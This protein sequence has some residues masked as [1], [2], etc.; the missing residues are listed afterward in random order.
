M[1][2]EKIKTPKPIDCSSCKFL[3]SLNFSEDLRFEICKSFWNLND[4]RRKKDFILM[5]V[6]CSLPKRRRPSKEPSE[7]SK[8]RTNSKSFFLL[9]KRV[10]QSFFLKTLA[11]SNGPLNKAFE[12]KNIYTNFFDG[13]DKRGK[14]TPSNKLSSA[15]VESVVNHCEKFVCQNQKSKR[16]TITN[17]D[18]RSLKQLYNLY[19]EDYEGNSPSYTSF[20][21]IF[22]ENNFAFPL[23]RVRSKPHPKLSDS[24]VDV[25]N[26]SESLTQ[27]NLEDEMTSNKEK[28]V[29][30]PDQPKVIVAQVPESS[31]YF[32]NPSSQVYE[33]QFIEI[34]LNNPVKEVKYDIY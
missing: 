18:I 31:K 5:N 4:Y 30:K 2:E 13:D 15:I 12:H 32:T 17:V 1:K 6:K 16:K 10:C 34:P 19:K 27:D 8:I 33:I 22:N 7:K 24:K 14:H 26:D 28:L 11:I 25:K 9:N 21:R 20:K 3:C 23:D 29:T